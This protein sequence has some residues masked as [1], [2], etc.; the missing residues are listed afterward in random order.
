M[1][2]TSAAPNKFLGEDP[3]VETVGQK[4]RDTTQIKHS[5]EFLNG[6][7]DTIK[8][9]VKKIEEKIKGSQPLGEA[10]VGTDGVDAKIKI[11]SGE[12]D[13]VYNIKFT[14]I[15]IKPV[16]I[17]DKKRIEELAA[18][19]AL[20]NTLKE[21]RLFACKVKVDG[22]EEYKFGAKFGEGE[23][24]FTI[25]GDN[26]KLPYRSQVSALEDGFDKHLALIAT[27]TGSGKT[28]TK[29]MFALVAKLR[30]MDVVSVTPRADLVGQEYEEQKG[31]VSK[32]SGVN[33]NGD[34]VKE[35][36]H[37]VVGLETFFKNSN[38]IL[39]FSKFSKLLKDEK[40]ENK[41]FKVDLK[42]KK[43]TIGRDIQI[44]EDRYTIRGKE[45]RES[46]FSDRKLLLMLDE[47]QDMVDK[48]EAYYKTTQLLL[49]LAH[50][51]KINL[52]ITTATPPVWM[53]D[54]IREEE[55]KKPA[56]GRAHI[57]AQSLQQKIMLGIGARI[58]VEVC[59]NVGDSDFVSKYVEYH[60]K[61]LLERSEGDK[62]YYYK[63]KKDSSNI[64][65]EIRKYI[66]WN[67]QSVRNRMT[68]ACM[69]SD[70]SKKQL[71]E[72][73][74][75]EKKSSEI[76]KCLYNS[77]SYDS[78][79]EVKEKL[80]GQFGQENG[81]AIDKVLKDFDYK[82]SIVDSGTFAVEHGIINNVISCITITQDELK[83]GKLEDKL[84]ELDN[85]RFSNIESFRKKVRDEIEKLKD[86]DDKKAHEKIEEYVEKL[87]ID[88]DGYKK[89]IKS[90]MKAVWKVLKESD[91]KRL[92]ELLDNH[93]LSKEIHRMMPP[94]LGSMFV[95]G[96]ILSNSDRDILN[97]LE[98][99]RSTFFRYLK[100][101]YEIDGALAKI[102]E[103]CNALYLDYKEAKDD[104]D[105]YKETKLKP[106]ENK[107]KEA[108][109][110]HTACQ[111]RIE[112]LKKGI[113]KAKG[114][115][116]NKIEEMKKELGK[117][118]AELPRLQ[119]DETEATGNMEACRIVYDGKAEKVKEEK[120]KLITEFRK[121][122]TEFKSK[123]NYPLRELRKICEELSVYE[124]QGKDES[125]GDKSSKDIETKGI[126]ESTGDKLS[127]AGL[128]G[129]YFNWERKSGYNNQV[130]H[131]VL[132][133]ETMEDN[134]ENKKQCVGRGG[135][136]KGP[137]ISLSYVD[138]AKINSPGTVKNQLTKGDPFDSL[139]EVKH[140]ID[141]KKYAER[142]VE[143]IEEV[144]N[145]KYPKKESEGTKE[146]TKFINEEVY[147]GLIGETFQ[148]ILDV[149]HEIYNRS[150]YSNEANKC[151]YQ[152]LKSATSTLK[153]QLDQ[154]G[155][156][157]GDC[158][159]ELGIK[160]LE[161]KI[162]E[163]SE[164]YK[165]SS[166]DIEGKQE[167]KDKVSN[168]LKIE[169]NF[170]KVIIIK[171]CTLVLRLWYWRF[172]LDESQVKIV[173]EK[174]DKL[175][176]KERVGLV[177]EENRTKKEETALLKVQNKQNAEIKSSEAKKGRLQEQYNK[178]HQ[179]IGIK[180][181]KGNVKQKEI[182]DGYKK[183]V[184]EEQLEYIASELK[185]VQSRLH[186]N[187]NDVKVFNELNSN[188]TSEKSNDRDVT[189]L[190]GRMEALRGELEKIV[191]LAKT[192]DV[193]VLLER[194][195]IQEP[196]ANNLE[197]FAK[198]ME[199]I[200]IR[201]HSYELMNDDD[202][203]KIIDQI[204]D[205]R[206]ANNSEK[207]EEQAKKIVE[208]LLDCMNVKK[209]VKTSVGLK[210][211]KGGRTK[212]EKLYNTIEHKIKDLS[213]TDL[214]KC[215]LGDA[216]SLLKYFDDFA[217][218]KKK[219]EELQKKK[220]QL[221]DEKNEL[222]DDAILTD[223]CRRLKVSE[224][225]NKN[226][227]VRRVVWLGAVLTE[228][229]PKLQGEDNLD[230]KVKYLSS[231]I[232]LE[233]FTN[234]VAPL[235]NEGNLKI[236][237]DIFDKSGNSSKD[238][239]E[240]ICEFYQSLLSKDSD[241]IKKKINEDFDNVLKNTAQLCV[242][243]VLTKFNHHANAA[244]KDLDLIKDLTLGSLDPMGLLKENFAN[245]NTD[246]EEKNILQD[247]AEKF[248]SKNQT[249][250][251]AFE[252]LKEHNPMSKG[253]R[254]KHFNTGTTLF[255]TLNAIMRGAAVVADYKAHSG[256]NQD[257]ML[258]KALG[259]LGNSS[260]RRAKE[261]IA[262]LG[263]DVHK[264]VAEKCIYEYLEMLRAGLNG[265]NYSPPQEPGDLPETSLNACHVQK[266]SED[267]KKASQG[268][269]PA[270]LI[271]SPDAEKLDIVQEK[272]KL[273]GIGK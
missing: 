126:N 114:A 11:E 59:K 186:K 75:K 215:N 137:I 88:N 239:A 190:E 247:I 159:I 20:S 153:K 67:M 56:E 46:I 94:N 113:E 140:K 73:L 158:E 71:K 187:E 51:K 16:Q 195:I 174:E 36:K 197:S 91:D 208:Q 95:Y 58:D 42:N 128:V 78:I 142:M 253:I 183:R 13:D 116:R 251:K 246:N 267:Y 107:F 31:A 272:V 260:I 60:N 248:F 269:L 225:I 100:E 81:E 201:L 204:N 82:G 92:N 133:R 168:K 146:E 27:A 209:E 193:L 179:F 143:K 3:K 108:E 157:V 189:I 188:T 221:E 40:A 66:I 117:A 148:H 127:K 43:I 24:E 63:P 49:L 119:K 15:T 52:V 178:M 249:T 243:I 254:G 219:I 93:N 25:G 129:Y 19:K 233:L 22:K 182:T 256:D 218:E 184:K 89:D 164:K 231:P 255:T 199:V 77:K 2:G 29:L 223:I 250:E 28:I 68:L 156:V 30:G 7:N 173:L 44:Y 64:E 198:G 181:I 35:Y 23:K 104:A 171:F 41:E 135:R 203:K 26:E 96:S 131:N 17:Q 220:K 21:V 76:G 213:S 222:S 34:Y 266:L 228:F 191:D 236:A 224:S 145:S 160:I 185:E 32:L 229:L 217:D 45:H 132:M 161:K 61:E 244:S 240:K 241:N 211:T 234:I 84:S 103:E 141:T 37:N 172:T 232:F 106:A 53:K 12:K 212:F 99:N 109:R 134:A 10:D 268:S 138:S 136:K 252:Y 226:Y 262:R 72:C 261:E 130:L 271:A 139:K 90:A 196:L 144:V 33:H 55:K 202:K 5:V 70:Q 235:A 227:D 150:G 123:E 121:I 163:L 18:F 258:N 97:I 206:N 101:H 120:G 80:L 175:T 177:R 122:E 118:T 192:K 152:V 38:E 105:S 180:E 245:N 79:S 257:S 83:K 194:L 65:E 112:E 238:G 125:T 115:D 162:G 242:L 207:Q 165:N 216:Q 263:K 1:T 149:R 54:Y 273:G 214:A 69:D 14:D 167:E 155:I 166:R 8:V 210:G 230:L 74:W 205:L 9:I 170:L 169:G 48:G 50:W 98:E 259:F 151:F 237:L 57:E 265:R 124:A 176:F 62:Y 200:A 4:V 110:K 147:N 85:Q 270:S 47:V 39:D 86:N 6:D 154:K 111:E 102:E 87:N 264:E